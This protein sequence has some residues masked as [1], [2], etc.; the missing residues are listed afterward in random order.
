MST[1]LFIA[2][3]GLVSTRYVLVMSLVRGL[4]CFAIFSFFVRYGFHFLRFAN[5]VF[6]LPKATALRGAHGSVFVVLHGWQLV[7]STYRYPVARSGWSLRFHSIAALQPQGSRKRK[8]G[9]STAGRK[10]RATTPPPSK[11]VFVLHCLQTPRF[12]GDGRACASP[13]Q[14]LPQP[15]GA[16]PG[17]L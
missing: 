14:G 17:P 11:H 4:L 16:G 10:S 9:C 12:T 1:G 8:N 13:T 5:R 3:Y 15:Q 7:S 6:H 2:V